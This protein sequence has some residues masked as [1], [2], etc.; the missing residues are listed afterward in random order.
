VFFRPETNL[1]YLFPAIAPLTVATAWLAVDTGRRIAGAALRRVVL[2]ILAA[3]ALVPSAR[4]AVTWTRRS[5]VLG[6]AVGSVSRQDY[7][8]AGFTFYAALAGA[9]NRN[10][11][12]DGKVLLLWEARGFYLAPPHLQDNI[13]TN[14]PLL[15]PWLDRTGDCLRGTGITHVLASTGAVG[16]YVSRGADPGVL[17]IDRFHAFADRCLMP[18]AGDPGFTLYRVK[19]PPGS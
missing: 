15:E 12:P 14:W 11:P 9:V 13:L 6:Q 3:V 8:A 17:G 18:V 7:L 4:S 19:D 5:P 16:Y 1:R 10:V 2:G